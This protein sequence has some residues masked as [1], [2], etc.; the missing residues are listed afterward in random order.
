MKARIDKKTVDGISIFH[1][2]PRN[3]Y[4]V[5]ISEA[6]DSSHQPSKCPCN[7]VSASRAFIAPSM[8]GNNYYYE[9][10]NPNTTSTGRIYSDD[11]LW[12]R[13]QCE[14]TCCYSSIT[15]SPSWFSVQ[16]PAPTNDAIEVQICG[17]KS[18]DNEGTPVEL[19]EILVQ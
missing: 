5:S 19:I 7:N 17:D 9:S 6:K 16:L 8:I 2:T 1:G 10:G 12:D 13:Q 4:V 18:T 11:K 3:R 15:K 14:G